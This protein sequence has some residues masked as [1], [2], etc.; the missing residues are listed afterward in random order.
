MRRI[1]LSD[2]LT[3]EATL[4]R[5]VYSPTGEVLARAG[6]ALTERS[7]R[8]LQAHGVSVCFVEDTPSSGVTIVPVVDVALRDAGVVRALRDACGVMWGLAER[9][10][11]LPTTRAV[12]ELKSMRIIGAL[13]SSGAAEAL[14][15]A[16]SGFVD[17]AVDAD[18]AAGF[19]TERQPAD[20]LYG[21]SVGVAA[22]AVRIGAAIGFQYGD[23]YATALAALTHDVGLLLV[24]EEIRR[25]PVAQRTAAQQRRYE[26]HTILGESLLKPLE[27]RQP[28]LPI[29]AVEHHEEQGG[30]GYPHGMQGGNRVLRP[31]ALADKR[32][33][34]VSEI[35]AVAD[36]YERLVSPSPGVE[37]LSPAAARRVVSAEAGSR[38]NAEVVGRFLD[39][40]P[41]WP[42][43]T[44]VILDGG[45]TTGRGV[46]VGLDPASP[47][48][49]L[50]RVYAD[51]WGERMTPVDVALTR[52]PSVEL[53]LAEE[54]VAAA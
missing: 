44:E 37:A 2:P 14:R 11:R 42:L 16:V 47:E 23:L 19:V 32:I 51:R 25:A 18:G 24:P 33:A 36:R 8:V 48:R 53:R 20:D 43:G 41:K 29:V 6:L 49:P 12:E 27:S 9:A 31:S 34:L 26:D 21:H 22:L 54:A 35:V 45:S 50:V 39:L 30:G 38:L 4:L 28:A 5:D 10:S 15:D 3:W 46:V 1:R 52:Q 17:R 13:D 7:A 40:L